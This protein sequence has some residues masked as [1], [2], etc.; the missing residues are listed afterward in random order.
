[1]EEKGKEQVGHPIPRA[2]TPLLQSRSQRQCQQQFSNSPKGND[3]KNNP[4]GL[5]HLAS[6]MFATKHKQRPVQGSSNLWSNAKHTDTMNTGGQGASAVS[7]QCW[8]GVNGDTWQKMFHD[9]HMPPPYCFPGAQPP[10]HQRTWKSCWKQPNNL[11]AIS[12][13][14]K[15]QWESVWNC[16]LVVL[17]RIGFYI[18]RRLSLLLKV[19][20]SSTYSAGVDLPPVPISVYMTL[21]KSFNFSMAEPFNCKT[22]LFQLLAVLS[23]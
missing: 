23:V 20:D 3:S 14:P 16:P 8:W 18:L 13:H 2:S 17:H 19:E 22:R 15:Y 21:K 7:A 6:F 4:D 12:Q 10:P 1:M 5:P 11:T 9:G